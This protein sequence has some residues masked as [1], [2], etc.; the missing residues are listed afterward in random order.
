MESQ[1]YRVL[2]AD[3]QRE[4]AFKIARLLENRYDIDPTIVESRD[5]LQEEI[6]SALNR[7]DRI[8]MVILTEKLPGVSNIFACVA[9]L[10]F[11]VPEG[12]VVA[13]MVEGKPQSDNYSPGV[14][15]LATP[16][17]VIDEIELFKL[18]DQT[19]SPPK[20]LPVLEILHESDLILQRQIRSLD[21]E[22]DGH[23]GRL[24][25]QRMIRRLRQGCR[26]ARVSRL[27]QGYSGSLVFRLDLDGESCVV[28]VSRS[29][30]LWK[31]RRDATHWNEIDSALSK[32]GLLAHAPRLLRPDTPAETGSPWV[33]DGDFQAEVWSLLGGNLGLFIDLED[34]YRWDASRP[35]SLVQRGF[36][37]HDAESL[38]E[39][40]L[41]HATLRLRECWYDRAQVSEVGPLWKVEDAPYPGGLAT[42]P[43]QLTAWWK[44]EI[45]TAMENLR[46]IGSRM[47]P[48]AYGSWN[49]D[50]AAIDRWI[51]GEP[52][53]ISLLDE[54]SHAVLSPVH[55]DLNRN[56]LLLW[57]DEAQPLFI[58]FVTYQPAGHTMQ[59]FACLETQIKFWLMDRET[60]SVHPALDLSPERFGPWCRMERQ[61]A[62]FGDIGTTAKSSKASDRS[63]GV[64]LALSMISLIR[65]EARTVHSRAYGQEETTRFATEYS[66]A[67][68]FHTLRSIAFTGLSPF[69]RLLAVFSAA[70]LIEALSSS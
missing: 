10:K 33:R 9:G 4:R 66:V 28:K 14:H 56:N 30:E 16:Q 50:T 58:D 32:G 37:A 54:K 44:A 70:R 12:H 53:G 67:L 60:T 49:G 36:F 35:A 62:S 21:P 7:G 63:A 65:S 26:T 11:L 18:L 52:S 41:R 31:I 64:G 3:R 61:L 23:N 47:F 42:P 39:S 15:F 48:G 22:H 27:T 59:D 8:A 13:L 40:L 34:A 43:Y 6:V 51:H 29:H 55:G 20:P 5:L 24:R 2:V 19:L 17:G 1:F 38:A 68:L 25:L 69:K 46:A 57:I 45:L